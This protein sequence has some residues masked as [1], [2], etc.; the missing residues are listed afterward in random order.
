MTRGPNEIWV[1]QRPPYRFRVVLNDVPPDPETADL[2]ALA[3]SAGTPSELG[4]T[5]EPARTLMF[6]PPNTLRASPAV[7]VS[8]PDPVTELREAISTGAAHDE[9]EA[10]LDGRTVRRVRIDPPPTCPVPSCSRKPSYAYVDP[11]TFY[12]AQLD[13]PHGYIAPADGRPVVRLHL[14]MRTLMFESLPRT[15]ATRALTD[16]EAQHRNASTGATG[17]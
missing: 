1:D 5:L 16:I 10:Q 12:P 11:E 7:F 3:C 4:G 9:G 2:R 8:R 6:V 13:S 15:P 17:R 14:V